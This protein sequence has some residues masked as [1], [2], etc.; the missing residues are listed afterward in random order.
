M[1]GKDLRILAV[2]AGLKARIL[3]HKVTLT[4]NGLA[5]PMSFDERKPVAPG[6]VRTIQAIKATPA[7]QK[8]ERKVGR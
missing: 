1:T 5:A 2:S 3:N 4:G 6:M 8:R 7:L